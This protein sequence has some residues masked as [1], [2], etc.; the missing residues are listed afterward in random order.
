MPGFDRT[1]IVMP[2]IIGVLVAAAACLAAPASHAQNTGAVFGPG[3][4]VGHRSAQ[5]R[6]AYDTDAYGFAQ[7]VH[8]QQAVNGDLQWRL[9]AQA[10]KTADSDVDTDF[11]QAE[12]FWQLET[13]AEHWLTGFRF[14]ARARTEGR[15]G[16]LGINWTND[17]RLAPNLTLR[18]IALTA[19]E[20]GDQARSGLALASRYAVLRSFGNAVNGGL[21][22]YS[23]HGLIDDIQPLDKTVHQLGP[24]IS[25]P[26]GGGYSVRIDSLFGLTDVSPDS[27]IR[28]WLSKNFSS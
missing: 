28:L 2:R 9:L 12:L 3:V 13:G 17:W 8:Y 1:L 16:Q 6:G 10:R 20:I 4:N 18:A 7:R 14:D 22:L 21:E 11:F 15:P 26:L 27:Q 23:N 25:R 19:Q 24:F 5:Y